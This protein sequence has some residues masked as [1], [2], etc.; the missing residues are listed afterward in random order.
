MVDLQIVKFPVA[1]HE[2][3]NLLMA[4]LHVKQQSSFSF[5][6]AYIETH[7]SQY[8]AWIENWE[9]QLGSGVCMT[10]LD[11]IAHMPASQYD[12]DWSWSAAEENQNL[13]LLK[14]EHKKT[15]CAICQR[16]TC[17]TEQLHL[18]SCVWHYS[19]ICTTLLIHMCDVTH[20]C[21][22]YD[23]YLERRRRN[24]H[25]T[26]VTS[27]WCWAL[28]HCAD[29]G[30]WHVTNAVSRITYNLL[31]VMM[32]LLLPKS[33]EFRAIWL[34]IYTLQSCHFLSNILTRSAKYKWPIP[35]RATFCLWLFPKNVQEALSLKQWKKVCKTLHFQTRQRL[36]QVFSFLSDVCL[37]A[38]TQW[39]T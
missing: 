28:L 11:M 18:F 24:S 15:A 5:I 31:C 10:P 7:T 13:V 1:N 27:S 12:C 2:I 23:S 25:E 14:Q 35:E 16:R 29:F 8:V 36:C 9:H 39:F 20:P 33:R 3:T 26:S 17:V 37:L 4:N 38:I 34:Q 21:E 30:V 22:C 19:F 32:S 6:Y